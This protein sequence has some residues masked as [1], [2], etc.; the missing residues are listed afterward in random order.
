MSSWTWLQ[1]WVLLTKQHG[2]WQDAVLL[3]YVDIDIN[4][5]IAGDNNVAL[6]KPCPGWRRKGR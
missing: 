4:V 1:T 5:N 6:S 2:D 3:F